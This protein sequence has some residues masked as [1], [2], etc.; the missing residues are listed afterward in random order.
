MR[1]AVV[2]THPVFGETE[3]NIERALALVADVRA[4]LFVLPELCTSGYNFTSTGEALSL[5]ESAEGSTFRAMAAFARRKSAYIVYGFAEKAD[6]LYNSCALV[7]PHGL[8]GIYRKVHLFAREKLIFAPGNLSFPVFDLPFGRVGMMICFDWIYPESARTLTLKGA[9]LIAHP[10]NLVLPHC[11]DAMVVRCLENGIF[12]VTA[13]RV[14][15]EDR[16]GVNLRFIG[17]SEII[18]PQGEI[19]A[20][21]DSEKEGVGVVEI[22]L[23]RANTKRVTELNDLLRDRR[24]DQYGLN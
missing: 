16:G 10:S 3:A 9:H 12:A 13:D 5:A 1:V 14:G 2:Q 24:P 6:R 4:D 7:G 11:P 18:S 15:R 23:A 8:V 19:L 22:D 20:R 21:L 17:T